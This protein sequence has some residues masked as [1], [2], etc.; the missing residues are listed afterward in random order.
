MLHY[1]ILV[2]ED[3]TLNFMYVSHLLD[4][5]NVEIIHARDGYEAVN[6][7][8][9]HNDISVILMDLRMPKMDGFLATQQIKQVLPNVP[10]IAVTA[11]SGIEYEQRAREAGCDDI[12]L[13]PIKQ[14]LLFSKLAE[15]SI[16]LQ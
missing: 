13:K 4:K 10:V 16:Q 1:T 15:Y 11:F 14:H 2:V 12:L 6:H 7:A 5:P 3:D 9:V 8:L